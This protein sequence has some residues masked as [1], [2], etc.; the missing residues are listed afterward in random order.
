MKD[1]NNSFIDIITSN[2]AYSLIDKPTHNSYFTIDHI[3]TNNTSNI[4][5]SSNF[6]QVV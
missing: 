3:L 1:F 6:F 4:I 2:G 5:F